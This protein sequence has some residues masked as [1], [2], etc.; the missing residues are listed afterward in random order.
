MYIGHLANILI[1][2]DN[3]PKSGAYEG[4]NAKNHPAIAFYLAQGFEHVGGT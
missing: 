3:F 1:F 4:T 2:P